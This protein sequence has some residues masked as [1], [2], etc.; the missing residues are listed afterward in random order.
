[1]PQWNG[2]STSNPPDNGS[3]ITLPPENVSMARSGDPPYLA[4]PFT[5]G[6]WSYADGQP[7]SGTPSIQGPPYPPPLTLREMRAADQ[8]TEVG[9]ALDRLQAQ[10]D[11]LVTVLNTDGRLENLIRDLALWQENHP[12]HSARSLLGKAVPED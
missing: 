6:Q 8:L 2:Y 7:R 11:L 1:M 12:R 10:V 5:S 4:A 9:V 3:Y